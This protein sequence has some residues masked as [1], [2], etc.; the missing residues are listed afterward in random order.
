MQVRTSLNNYRSAIQTIQAR[1][2]EVQSAQETYRFAER[3]FREGQ[4]LQ[5]ELI[6]A[7]TQLTNAQVNY[8]LAQLAVLTRAAELERDQPRRVPGQQR[9]VGRPGAA[10]ADLHGSGL[11]LP[12][13]S[14]RISW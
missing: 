4:A 7:R 3:R 12:R 10:P 13:R 8:S 11:S 5:I 1:A 2:D 6:D 14:A 9:Q